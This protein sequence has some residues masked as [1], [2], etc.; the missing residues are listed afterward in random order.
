AATDWYE[1]GHRL[2][3]RIVFRLN[4][5]LFLAKHLNSRI[6]Q[7]GAEDVIN[8]M[9]ALDQFGAD[10]NHR[11]SHYQRAENAPKKYPVLVFC[12]Y[13]KIGKDQY[14]DEQVIDREG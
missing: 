2:H 4:F 8:P 12:R 11:Y 6:D 5:D 3:D 9:E 1:S 7:K 10:E 13:L 14:K